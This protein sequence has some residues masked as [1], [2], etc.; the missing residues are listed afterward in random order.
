[1][2][3]TPAINTVG[4]ERLSGKFEQEVLA[5]MQKHLPA[6]LCVAL[7]YLHGP[8]GITK[9]RNGVLTWISSLILA[10]RAADGAVVRVSAEGDHQPKPANFASWKD[11]LARLSGLLA[12]P[13]DIEGAEA[14]VD[15]MLEGFEDVVETE[16]ALS[17]IEPSKAEAGEV[18]GSVWHNGEPPKPWRDEW[19]IA[20][21]IHGDRVVLRSLPEE[22]TYDYKTADETYIMARNIKRWMQFPDS[23]FKPYTS[24]Q[25][26]EPEG[27]TV[28]DEMVERAARAMEPMA[29]RA[30]PD[31][32]DE[33]G[34]LAVEGRAQALGRARAALI[35]ALSGKGR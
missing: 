16:V 10:R 2:T 28:T 24:P 4:G 19:F 3:P 30:N 14:I 33:W 8:Y 11:Q 12:F 22:W 15:E 18:V 6:E 27:V 7:T 5:A 29:F 20:L 32:M 1:M 35:A 23:S 34:D 21:T 13:P 9:V 25:G 31:H 26:N 17:S